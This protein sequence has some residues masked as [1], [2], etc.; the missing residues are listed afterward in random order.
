M[1]AFDDSTDNA[2]ART[3]EEL[4]ARLVVLSEENVNLRRLA[5][6]HEERSHLVEQ[7]R[8]ANENLLL[9]SLNAQQL[10]EQA[11]AG[12]RRQSE[13]LAMLAHE[14]RNPLAPIRMASALLARE[15]A[16][17]EQLQQLQDI[18]ERQVGHLTGLLDNLLDAS[19][20]ASGAVAMLRRPLSL[21][22]LLRRAMEKIRPELCTLHQVL[23]IALPVPMLVD[24][25]QVRLEQVFANLLGNASKYTQEGGVIGVSADVDAGCAVVT[26]S[27]NGSGIGVELLPHVF[28]LFTQGPR[29]RARSEGGLGVGLHIVRSIVYQHGGSVAAYSDGPGKGSSFVVTL[30]LSSSAPHGGGAAA[31]EAPDADAAARRILLVEDNLDANETLRQLLSAEG[32]Q[33]TSAFDGVAGLT[34]ALAHPF[35]ILVC[36]I[37]LP[38]IDGL[39]LITRLRA[40]PVHPIPFAIAISGYGDAD[41]RTLAIG[42]G[43]GQYFVKPVDVAALLTLIGSDMAGNFIANARRRR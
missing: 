31:G 39:E 30:P 38:G 20:V 43:F 12:A 23:R 3:M 25:D 37:G 22:A 18:I 36:D 7:L 28:G 41:N 13:F 6:Q 1:D 21:D 15:P 10:R 42:A 17:S 16:P 29:S 9:A 2:P 24:G 34:L 32:H 11:D 35:D 8:E 14:L 33:V 27:D 26:I 5:R 40:N 4:R 19:H